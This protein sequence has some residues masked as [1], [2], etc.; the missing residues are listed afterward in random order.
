MK[1]SYAY[2]LIVFAIAIFGSL[3]WLHFY[4]VEEA[5]A[6]AY[7]FER[8]TVWEAIELGEER[9]YQIIGDVEDKLED[10]SKARYQPMIPV[11][12]SAS[13]GYRGVVK[14]Y[15]AMGLD[16]W[17]SPLPERE[18][19]H[20]LRKLANDLSLELASL[21]R[22]YF[23]LLNDYGE[24]FNLNKEEVEA[25]KKFIGSIMKEGMAP[26]MQDLLSG[27]HFQRRDILVL[28]YLSITETMIFDITSMAGGKSTGSCIGYFP[29]MITDMENP[30]P[31]ET[32]NANLFIGGYSTCLLPEY[33]KIIVGSDT[34][35][36]K[37]DGKV[38]YKF[39]AGHR[40]VNTISYSSLITNPLTGYTIS[41]E[42]KYTYRVD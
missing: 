20:L 7:E 21:Q 28:A 24:S 33:S 19:S 15:Q 29:V 35:Q 41:Q 4:L 22:A 32:V 39:T 11:I 34:L 8:E 38:D 42:G 17:G 30:R 36:V 2:A 31:G 6:E 26:V 12:V 5:L 1:R 27:N 3:V 18:Q 37:D 10:P 13:E 9:I 16:R 25:K 14:S 23:D 40:G